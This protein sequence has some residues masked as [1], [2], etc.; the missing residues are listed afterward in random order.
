MDECVV[1]PHIDEMAKLELQAI[2]DVLAG[3][4]VPTALIALQHFLE[5]VHVTVPHSYHESPN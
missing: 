2:S 4:D 1:M 3:G 5:F